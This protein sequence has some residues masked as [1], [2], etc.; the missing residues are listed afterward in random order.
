MGFIAWGVAL[1][2]SEAQTPSIR[3]YTYEHHQARMQQGQH[4]E[5]EQIFEQ[6][7]SNRIADNSSGF[8]PEVDYNIPVV[9]H[10]IYQNASDAWNISAAQIQSQVD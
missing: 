8:R 3:C 7:M 10:V 1:V 2:E 9:F 6:W 5:S 4:G